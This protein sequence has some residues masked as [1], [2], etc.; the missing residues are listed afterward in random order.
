MATEKLKS[1]P[2]RRFGDFYRIRSS[3]HPNH[4]RP[5]AAASA[6]LCY[7]T[8]AARNFDW[9]IVMNEISRFSFRRHI[10]N[11]PFAML[12]SLRDFVSSSKE[13]R[14]GGATR[15]DTTSSSS[16]KP[17]QHYLHIAPDG[18][19]WTGYEIF[20]AKHLQ[21]DY[22][23]SVPIPPPDDFDVEKWLDT[24]F[25]DDKKKQTEALQKIYDEG[26][27]PSGVGRD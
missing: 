23:R 14:T 5:S 1:A 13:P 8:A 18:D 10:R 9:I 24:T 17:K 26:K 16:S 4:H 2:A 15:S 11:S 3:N 6:D 27:L 20:A 19:Y 22:V 12:N 21:P 7:L 25:G